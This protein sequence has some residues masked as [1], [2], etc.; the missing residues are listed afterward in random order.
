MSGLL[1]RRNG[2]VGGI[3]DSLL[4]FFLIL[5][6]IFTNCDMFGGRDC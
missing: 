4:F 5:V 6:I 3:D 1:G 2:D